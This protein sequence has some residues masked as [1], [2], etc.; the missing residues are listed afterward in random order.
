VSARAA[1]AL[2]AACGV[3]SAPNP[4][5][6]SSEHAP[7]PADSAAADSAAP[8]PDC[9]PLRLEPAQVWGPGDGV[10]G[11]GAA[12]A[13]LDGDG[14]LDALLA[15]RR[16]S[17]FLRNDGGAL[18]PDPSL[19]VDGGPLPPAQSVAFA[20]LD[21]DGD[22]DLFLGTGK[23]EDDLLL[24]QDAPLAFR[25][26]PLPSSRGFTGTGTFADFDGDGR[27]DL[28]V[29]RRFEADVPI[30]EI[31]DERPPGDPSS[32]YLQRGRGSFTDA[33]DR[34]PWQ[35]HAAHTQEAAAFD[36]DGDGD[37]DLYLANDF[38]PFIVPN[39]LLRNDG[40]GRFTL[41]EGCFCGLAMYGMAAAPGDLDGDGRPDLWLT[42]IGG[43][44]LLK[45]AAD[46]TFVEAAAAMGASLGAAPDRLVS[47]GALAVDL[48]LD[49]H[50]DLPTA[51]GAIA[52]V[53][54]GEVGL[55]GDFT[56]DEAQRDALL[57]GGDEGFTEISAEQGFDRPEHHR[58]LVRGDL[59]GDL[60]DE[61]LLAGP[62]G[63][64]IWRV[65]G[66]CGPV[67]RVVLQG[68]PGNPQAIGARIDAPGPDG[69]PRARW[70]NPGG[71]GSQSDAA[72]AFAA[73]PSGALPWLTVTWPGGE[74]T[75][76]GPL[77]PGLHPIAAP[78]R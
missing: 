64:R 4:D 71:I 39:Q 7:G 38:G 21:E 52:E 57:M 75:R 43:P 42:D 74:Q 44:K 24:F 48:D 23:G 51:F 49:G 20:D 6:G 68:P 70:I 5:G 36:A 35:I 14:D 15:H 41:D 37:L 2:L 63:A 25:A 45:G 69:R 27:L 54:R 30:S 33:S 78:G 50:L 13:D 31:L 8:P 28:F 40:A 12:L 10:A 65:T 56:W 59:D 9:A 72:I 22:L 34:L 61:L 18:A 66:G 60:Q 58:A 26:A 67:I 77:A 17:V 11:W 47:W 29:G 19:T 46:G 16:G 1:L 32:L 76:H 55:L 53:Q 73:D 62:D 3:R